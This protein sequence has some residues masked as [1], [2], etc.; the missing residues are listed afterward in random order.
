MS[1]IFEEETY[2][3]RGAVFFGSH[4]KVQIERFAL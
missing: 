4:P 3:I 1:L 2:V